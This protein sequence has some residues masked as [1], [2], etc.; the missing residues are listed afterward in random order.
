MVHSI[1]HA[2]GGATLTGPLGNR[3]WAEL[4]WPDV[5]WMPL[6]E[7]ALVVLVPEA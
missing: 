2:G 3:Q 6:L 4:K 1:S 5:P 7:S